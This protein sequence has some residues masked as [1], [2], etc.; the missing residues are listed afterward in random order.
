MDGPYINNVAEKLMIQ[1][2]PLKFLSPTKDFRRLSVLLTIHN[3]S[4]FSQ[5]RIGTI[6]NLS[7]SMV[8][9]YVRELH[10]EDLITVTGNTNRS[11]SYHLTAAG[12][13][14]LR[15]SLDLYS[16]EITRIFENTQHELSKIQ[17]LSNSL[18]SS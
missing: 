17:Q 13:E 5:H 4:N 9:N 18:L 10:E 1:P 7:S 3:D 11:Q 2:F 12:I 15:S 6:T 14:E 16:A 8:N